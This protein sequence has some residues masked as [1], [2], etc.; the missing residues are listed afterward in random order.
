MLAVEMNKV[1]LGL[2]ILTIAIVVGPLVGIVLVYRDNLAG[3]VFPPEIQN[4]ANNSNLSSDNYS[5]VGSQFQPPQLASEPKYNPDTGA[6]SVAYNFTNPTSTQISID[7]LSADI[8]SKNDN[9]YLGN[10]SINQPI[11]LNPGEN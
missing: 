3:L 4:I 11:Q 5:S 10:V 6:F 8:R 2:T 9:E 7:Q 1:K